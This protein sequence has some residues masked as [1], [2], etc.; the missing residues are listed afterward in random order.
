VNEATIDI[1]KRALFQPAEVCEIASVQPYVLRSWESEFPDLGV[2]KSGRGPRVYRRTDV[3]RVLRIRQLV[4]VDGL[5]L[6]GVRRRIEEETAPETVEETPFEELLGRNARQRLLEVKNGLRAILQMLSGNGSHP[7][8]ERTKP[9]ASV[10]AR[11]PVRRS[12][13]PTA[14]AARNHASRR[15]KG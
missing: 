6:A 2:T 12:P 11:R 3:E 10:K 1:P 5:T 8:A 4:F 13:K 9:R 7:V 14:R 15:R